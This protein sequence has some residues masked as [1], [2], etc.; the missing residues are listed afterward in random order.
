[1]IEITAFTKSGGPLT[2]RI[3]LDELGKVVS[4]GSACVM[5]AGEGQRV[6]LKGVRQL[7][8]LIAS[9]GSS[10]AIALGALRDGIPDKVEIITKIRLDKL[11]GAARPDLIA[12]TGG[13]IA[14]RRKQPAF[15]L[16]DFDTKG[17]P[18]EVERR[19]ADA[20]GFWGVVVS[21]VPSLAKVAHVLRRSTSAGLFRSD[22]GEKLPGSNGI[23]VYLEVQDGTDIDRFLRVLHDRCWL[24][25]LGWMMVG[26]GGQL[27]DR[28]IV[29]RMV[30]APERL[31]FEGT[32]VLV[33]PLA[34][35]QE[36]RK[37]IVW[38]GAALDTFAACL[39]LTIVEQAKLREL[40]S[41]EMHRLAPESA[42]ARKVFIQEQSKRHGVA[43]EVM[44]RLCHGVLLPGVVLP[45]DDPELV[46][47]TVADVL[48]DPVRFEGATLADPV[49]G[50]EYG[51]C[52]AKIMLHADGT[53]WIH[54][55]AH[56][57]AVY[58][59]KLDAAAVRQAVIS[60]PGE[61]VAKV[62]VRLALIADLGADELEELRNLTADKAGVG[63]LA[64]KR[65][66][67]DAMD[68]QR[69]QRAEEERNRR[70]AKRRDPRPQ[71][72]AP[73]PD[74]PW[75]PQMEAL[76]DVLG[77]SRDLEPP[78]RDI[79]GVMVQVRVRRVPNMHALSPGG[80]N[81]G[82]TEETRLPPPE[83]P[84]LIRLEEPQLAEMIER[85]IE[86]VDEKGR[87]VHLATP[88]VRH[89]H[90][91]ADDALPLMAAIATLPMVLG[92]GTLL[93]KPGLDR[94]RGI[95]F[96]VPPELV[97]AL[98]KAEDCSPTAVAEA[99]QFLTDEWLCDLATNYIGRCILIASALTVIERSLLPKRPLFY[100]TAGRRG[101]GKTTTLIMLLTAVTGVRPS[102]AAWSS[103]EEE[104]R[105]ALLAYLLEALPAIVWDNIP[106]GTQISCPHIEKACTTALYS[107]RRLGVSE[108]IAVAAS[109]IQFFTGNNIG[110]RGDSASRSLQVRLEVDR[111]DPE[112]RTFTHPDP[113]GWTEAHRGRI[114][115]ALYTILLGN[116]RLRVTSPA[117]AATRFKTWLHLVGSAV[118][119]AAKQHADH[120]NAAV[121]DAPKTCRP[122]TISFRDQFLAQ[123]ED[124]EESA[125][126]ADALEAAAGAW[127]GTFSAG[128]VAKVV[129]DQSEYRTH[130]Q[131]Q[132]SATL[133]EFLFPTLPG[134]QPATAKAV[135]KR[136]KR[137]VGEP[138]RRE[139]RTLIL[140][141]WHDLHSKQ[142]AYSVEV[143]K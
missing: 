105:K 132:R 72:P 50:V 74:A 60:A 97:A 101:G 8:G 143:K 126:L 89:F 85:H 19:I 117:Q 104:R 71:I 56:G 133:R 21:V 114:L 120:V 57:R 106:R 116:P 26:R 78:A 128:D 70:A 14:Y 20:G 112:N 121:M 33:A 130:E 29:D 129:N 17:M 93:S 18:R 22:T 39:P 139:D 96:R 43:P 67:R 66:L 25:G 115:A 127:S 13:H 99:M 118:E 92:N 69:L 6:K 91:R 3:S 34:Q 53:A 59:L 119:Y 44:E 61:T 100:V 51:A 2:K 27:L 95:V 131:V 11:N 136:L 24:N 102:A 7:A 138:V 113:V 125:S 98:P 46:G 49:E 79:D 64:I 124:D 41:K 135:A 122:T 94:D 32:P 81:D 54:S 82:D 36:A 140:R 12:R 108:T 9:L 73:E 68:L 47:T 63:K 142:I 141:T 90:T 10:D 35:D 103:S 134:G 4:D 65:K 16:L 86:Y 42:K 15:A 45:F 84:L 37:P 87:P 58:E 123:E 55:F 48:A 40:R 109:V 107:D 83:Q 1:M 77:K 110:P 23:H 28:S 75:L 52:K 137:H 80:V 5:S 88:F 38:E 76:N 62:F 30:G 31:V 111:A